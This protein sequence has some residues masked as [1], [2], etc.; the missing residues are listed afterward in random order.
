MTIWNRIEAFNKSRNIPK[1]MNAW[2]EY[3]N[4]KEELEEL[5]QA[6][7]D[8]DRVDAFCDII[9]FA[10]GALWKL[11]YDAEIAMEETLNEIEDREQNE[12]QRLDWLK[13]GAKG[14]WLKNLNQ[15]DPYKA[16]YDLAKER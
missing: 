5:V 7:N 14:K 11:G 6:E 9:V 3:E 15:I 16:N 10:V 2:V 13:N 12:E 4:I 8:N 1:R